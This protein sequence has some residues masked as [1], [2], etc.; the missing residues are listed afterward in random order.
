[1]GVL[2][3]AAS[4]AVRGA[5]AGMA[6]SGVRSV[7][8][9]LDLVSRT[10]PEAVL[11]ETAPQLLTEVPKEYRPAAVQGLHWAFGAAFGA[12]FGLLP[13]AVRRHPLSGP[14]YGTLVWLAFE[15]GFAPALGLR[16]AREGRPT[17]RLALLADHVL[18]GLVL[19]APDRARRRPAS[20]RSGG[21]PPQDLGDEELTRELTQLYSTRDD[22]LRH[23]S[24]QA[25]ATHTRRT[26]ELEAEYLRRFPDREVDPERLREGARQRG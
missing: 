15:A 11:A 21:V 8:F 13:G 17:E 10:P 23:G 4:G 18:Y 22:T 2:R 19:A 14:V 26:Q 3:A 6:M 1:M 5:V 7:T 20:R 25:L 16:E 9:G 12:L 24:D